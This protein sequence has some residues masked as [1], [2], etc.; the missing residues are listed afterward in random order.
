MNISFEGQV[1][2]VSGAA[3]GFG[4]VIATTFAELGAHVYAC[5]IRAD[6][7]A[8]LAAPRI[9]TKVVDLTDRTAAAAWVR[10]IEEHSGRALDV[11]VNNAGGVAGQAPRPVDEVTDEQWDRVIEINLGTTFSL[12]RAA[13][14]G[15]KRAGR[16]AII[17]ISSGAALQASLTGVQAYCSAKHAVLGL[18]RQLAHELGPHGIR[19]NSV[20][21]GFVR[22]N[23]AT[24]KQWAAMGEARQ[25]SLLDGIA[26]RRFG[27]P[28]DITRAVLFFASELSGFVNG[29]ILSVDGGR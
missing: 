18:T 3:I 8:T 29:Q 17:N 19:V 20:A 22:T 11:L 14:P 6:E 24:E 12:S 21:P 26:L 27:T 13:A 4:R 25:R 10:G 9:E 5:D 7:L 23:D 1:V 16:G 2:A 28:E 15:M